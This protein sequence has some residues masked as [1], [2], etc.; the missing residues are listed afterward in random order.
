MNLK[1]KGRLSLKLFFSTVTPHVASMTRMYVN[2]II[3]DR[4]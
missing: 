2:D 4:P 1:I 3:V